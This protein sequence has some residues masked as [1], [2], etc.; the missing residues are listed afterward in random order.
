MS[1][2]CFAAYGFDKR[3]AVKNKWR[4]PELKLHFFEFFGGWPGGLMGQ[5]KFRH[6]TQK[7]SYQFVFWFIVLI[8][9]IVW[10]D[11]LCFNY[12]LKNYI[13]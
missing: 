7:R 11:Y 3:K 13:L 9:I 5:Q 2:F 6:K 8:H 12:V 4:I 1:L 10:S